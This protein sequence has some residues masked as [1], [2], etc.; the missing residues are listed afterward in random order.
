MSL[1]YHQ[2]NERTFNTFLPYAKELLL[3]PEKNYL[4]DLSYL[5]CLQVIGEQARDFLQ[6][7]LSCDI[8]QVTTNE[9]RQGSMCNLKGR[10]LALMDVIFSEHHGLNLVLPKDLLSPTEASLAKT[11]MLSRVTLQLVP[12]FEVFGFYLQNLD[13]S[14][15]LPISYP[16]APL[17]VV[18]D[19]DYLVYH[20]GQHFYIMLIKTDKAQSIRHQFIQQSQYL[21]SLTWHTLQLRQK[22]IEI[23]ASSRGLFLPHRLHLHLSGHIDFN[24]GCYKGQEIIART[25]YR[26]TLKHELKLFTIH[27]DEMLKSGQKLFSLPSHQEVGELIDFS[28]IDEQT[29]LIAASVFFEHPTT[30]LIEGHKNEVTLLP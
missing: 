30:V 23:Y 8:R 21:G 6:G 25:H 26:A 15:P 27:T 13:E 14:L 3:S 10:V 12:E 2:I 29:Y 7:Q 24:K 9:I 4:F 22:R 19:E 20:L 5:T 17:G 18:S 11:A 1:F 16:N 28:P